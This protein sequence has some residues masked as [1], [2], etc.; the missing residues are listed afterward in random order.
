MEGHE[1]KLY[2]KKLNQSLLKLDKIPLMRNFAPFDFELFSSKLKTL[3]DVDNLEVNL[4]NSSW[5]EKDEIEKHISDNVSYLGFTFS[6]ILGTVYLLTAEEDISKLINEL[7][8]KNKKI[9][10]TSS[11]LQEGYFRFLSLQTLDILNSLNIF[12]DLSAKII[13]EISSLDESCFCLDFQIKINDT[14]IFVKIA[15]TP[16]FRE[17][18]EEYF[19]NNPPL[20]AL[21]LSKS[22]NLLMNIE[23]GKV[24]MSY[25]SLK[26]IE[27]C[28]FVILD[29]INYDPKHNKGV[30]TLRLNDFKMFSAKIKQNKLN[31]LDLSTVEEVKSMEKASENINEEAADEPTTQLQNL[32]V[33]IVVE[34]ARYKITLDKLM[35]LQ[36]GN[37]LDLAVHPERG[38]DLTVNG[39]IFAKAELMQIGDSLGVKITKIG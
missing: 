3:L 33:T 21:E 30:V 5:Q 4:T 10:I 11:I 26:K 25:E 22:L 39:E 16:K 28:D 23:L 2:L 14:S 27:V 20:K 9:K 32:P 1:K 24:S 6:P 19:I 31:I 13:D 15:V 37:I 17:S 7:T 35:N 38:V 29:T 36:P 34:A 12:Q 8:L 18:W